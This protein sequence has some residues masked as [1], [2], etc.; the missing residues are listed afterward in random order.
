[1]KRASYQFGNQYGYE[2]ETL[3][4]FARYQVEAMEAMRRKQYEK[5]FTIIDVI[6]V[7]AQEKL[8]KNLPEG[9]GEKLAALDKKIY[10]E[11]VKDAYSKSELYKETRLLW[12]LLSEALIKADLMFHTQVDPSSMVIS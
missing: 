5:L 3:N 10:S 1:M 7:T 11:G 2:A 12:G 9:F 6:F 8:K 4:I